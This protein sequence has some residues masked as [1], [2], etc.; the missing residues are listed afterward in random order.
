MWWA[1][2]PRPRAA[3]A[4]GAIGI[5]FVGTGTAMA[6]TESAGVIA[7]TNWN[8]ATGAS[9]STA[10]ALK[11][12]TG[13]ATGVTVTWT[14]DNTWATPVTDQAGS[15]RMMK[16]YLDQG[17][18]N[19][20]TVT[21]AGLPA[22][23]YDIYLYVDG[24]NGVTARTSAY[25]ISGT[26]ITATTINLT[27]PANTNF[28]ATF[29]PANNSNGNYVKFAGINVTSGFTLTATPGASTNGKRAPV[30][31]IQIVPTTPPPPPTPDFTITATPSSRTVSQGNGASYTFT[32]GAL[33]G[34][35]SDVNLSV[36]GLPAN[37]TAT[38]TPPTIS[39][40]GSA[41]LDVMTAPDTPAGSA[42]LTITASCTCGALTHA[43]TVS[44]VVSPPPDFTIAATPATQKVAQGV[45]TSYTVSIGALNGFTATTDLSVSGLPSNATASFTSSSIAGAGSTTLNVATAAATPVGSSTL[46]ITGTS[47]AATHTA[48]VSLL[49]S[50]PGTIGIHFVGT[51]TAMAASETAGVI[52][53]SNW[54]NATSASRSTP[55]ALVDHTGAAT[56]VAATWS[57]DNTNRTGITD[58]AGNYRLMRGYLDQSS[59]HATTVSVTGVPPTTY[60][61]YVYADGSN[62]TSSRTGGYRISG[63]GITSTTINLTD[64]ANAN[65]NGTFTQAN[66][67][68]GNYVRFS[69]IQ[70]G[71]SG[72]TVTAT[73]GASSTSTRRAPVNAIQIVPV[74]PPTPDFTIA[75]APASQAVTQ[76][77]TASY[78]VTV[79]AIS[80]FSGTVELTA[81][82]LPADAIASFTPPA[83]TGGG[84]ATLDVATATTTPTGTPTVTVTGSSS[85]LTHSAAASLTINAIP[86]PDFTITASPASKTVT[87]G[88]TASYTISVGALNGFAGDVSLSATG[89]PADAAATFTPSVITAPGDATLDV[90]TA[91]ST[92]P[93]GASLTITGT[94]ASASHA[95][96]AALTV[97]ALTYSLSG[98][99]TP[100]P[101]GASATVDL[102]GAATATATADTSGRYSF[103]GL[104][105]GSYAV[106]PRKNGFSFSP[107]SQHPTVDGG[108]VTGIDFTAMPLPITVSITSPTEGAA[109]SR[110]FTISAS[111]SAG[112]ASVQFQVD[113]ANAGPEDTTAPFSVSLSAPTGPHVLTAIAR[114]AAGNSLTSQ[115]VHVTVDAG[116]GTALTV[117]GTQTFQTMDGFGVNINSLSWKNGQMRPAIDMLIDQM[118]VTLWR[119]VFDMEDWEDPNDD[120]DPNVPNWTYYN[121]LYSNAKFQNLWGT[122]H[123]LNQ[124]GIT[125]GIALSFMGRVPVWMGGAKI[126]TASEDEWVELMASLFYYAKNVEHVEFDIVDPLN[127]PDWDGF[128]G[129]QVAQQQYVRLLEKLS[130]RLDAMGLSSYRF[131]GP[132]T[133]N[134]GSAVSV[135][136]PEMMRNT[137]VMSK[138]DHIALHNYG[139]DSAG[140]ANAIKNSAYPTKNYWITE[141]FQPSDI[142]GHISQGTAAVLMWDALD[143]V[144][145]HAILAGRGTTPPNDNGP[146]LPPL[147]YNTTTGV[148]TPRDTFYQYAQIFKYVPRG[149]IR[150]SATE[151]NSNLTIYAFR[152]P[153]SGRVTLVGRNIG[154]SSIAL[155]A[156]MTGISG[157]TDFQFY[158][159]DVSGNKFKRGNDVVVTNGAF[160]FTAPVNSYFTLTTPAT[161]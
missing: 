112:V 150:V 152:D 97:A 154:A 127:E 85:S 115:A 119:V 132:N 11:D 61:V 24:D 5:D 75:A 116:S 50:A 82:G 83:I 21:V 133:A 2:M 45:G 29:T 73:P 95:A 145:N 7:K 160:V 114:D 9:R 109:L 17:S 19:A 103:T 47:G 77:Q 128:E 81:G 44:L 138:V 136:M 101:N 155:N 120:S 89:L 143:S 79:A 84:T 26:G 35:S 100:A 34:F 78:T 140:A 71:S 122:L 60:D 156:T 32:V 117:N 104:V 74:A 63:S 59:G 157:V 64:A 125:T 55:L 30:N 37:T 153:V 58:Q 3:T 86:T 123:Y 111:G 99:I 72:F 13:A 36:S 27:D 105:N 76:G 46:T 33:N 118:G 151:S 129:P 126:N 66:N 141:T 98:A 70:I 67:S 107:T 12:E 14:S 38:F 142:L 49:V 20:T 16:G 137:T 158:Q 159:T 161:P 51:G 15:R 87:Q 147:A 48:T 113:G 1:A 18:G 23:G 94:G 80:G 88:G 106:M 43:A 54:N 65:F 69:S 96:S 31:G 131:L 56:M 68:N 110:T 130:V 139:Q 124:K 91:A 146:G 8:S 28:N 93:G 149:S 92:P 148:Y 121:A 102:G 42:T 6:A 40:S 39:T 53:K 108:D 57:S 41:T 62:S 52:A 25:T 10:L 144:Y 135:Y 4:V 134:A 90:T 22:A